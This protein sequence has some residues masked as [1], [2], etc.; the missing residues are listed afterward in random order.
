MNKYDSTEIDRLIDRAG[1]IIGTHPDLR[2]IACIDVALD[3]LMVLRLE[4]ELK[5][6]NEGEK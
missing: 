1:E 2:S 5:R 4:V 3:Y 6:K